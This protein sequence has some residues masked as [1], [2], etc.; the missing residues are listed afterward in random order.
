MDVQHTTHASSGPAPGNGGG[1]P[2]KTGTPSGGGRSNNPPAKKISGIGLLGLCAVILAACSSTPPTW[3]KE[4][5]SHYDMESQQSQCQ[6]ESKK[7]K[8]P[9]AERNEFLHDCMRSKGFRWR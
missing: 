4:G 2:S 5:V 6:L 8:I 7:D 1:W 3:H 9:H